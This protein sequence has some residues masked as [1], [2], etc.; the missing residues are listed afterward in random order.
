MGRKTLMHLINLMIRSIVKISFGNTG[1]FY[2]NLK[3]YIP[4]FSTSTPSRILYSTQPSLYTPIRILY[5]TK[6]SLYSNP[7]SL[8]YSAY[9]TFTPTRI[10]YSFQPSLF[11]TPYSLLHSTFFLLYPVFF[12]PSRFL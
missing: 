1:I 5:Y 8:F 3:T 10:L 7:Y 11:S 9:S 2:N 6:P 4:T 12:T